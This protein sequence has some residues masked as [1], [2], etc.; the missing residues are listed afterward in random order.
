MDFTNSNAPTSETF[1]VCPYYKYSVAKKNEF[2]CEIGKMHFETRNSRINYSQKYC[3][4]IHNWE[5]CTLAQ[6]LTQ[7]IEREIQNERIKKRA[8]VQG[9]TTK[10][11]G[12]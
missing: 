5:K 12:A 4:N 7:Q 1:I 9:K 10:N 11:H 2:Y 3:C 8:R 6:H